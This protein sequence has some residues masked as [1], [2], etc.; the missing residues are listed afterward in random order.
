MSSILGYWLRALDL[1]GTVVYTLYAAFFIL[2]ID[3][4]SYKCYYGVIAINGGFIM[5]TNNKEVKRGRINIYLVQ[6]L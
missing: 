5:N 1:N 4:I 3:S 6:E 2:N